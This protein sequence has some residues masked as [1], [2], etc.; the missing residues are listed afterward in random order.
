MVEVL[1]TKMTAIVIM[2]GIVGVGIMVELACMVWVLR[3]YL[4]DILIELRSK[5]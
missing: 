4:H 3:D 5:R 1:E 2:I